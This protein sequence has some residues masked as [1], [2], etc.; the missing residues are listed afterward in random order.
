[1]TDIQISE[2]GAGAT[3]CRPKASPPPPPHPPQAPDGTDDRDD[4]HGEVTSAEEWDDALR[5]AEE[6][7]RD[8][9]QPRGCFECYAHPG[10]SDHRRI[11]RYSRPADLGRHFR[12]EHL[13]HLKDGEPAWCSWCE[14]KL[15]HRMDVQDHAKI[16]HRVHT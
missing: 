4:A 8:V 3:G 14:I 2:E 5:A 7:I 12:D 6:H 13:R 16:V 1:M 9:K 10:S 11:H 15:E